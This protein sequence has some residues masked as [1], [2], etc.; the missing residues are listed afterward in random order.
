M[1]R[2]L[3]VAVAV[4]LCGGGLAAR[5]VRDEREA[6][7]LNA[8]GGDVTAPG[9]RTRSRGR[10][11]G[12][13]WVRCMGLIVLPGEV[14]TG[15]HARGVD[16][17]ALPLPGDAQCPL[18]GARHGAAAAP[19]PGRLARDPVHDPGSARAEPAA[20]LA[21][22]RP[23]SSAWTSSS[24]SSGPLRP[25][26]P[27]PPLTEALRLRGRGEGE[28]G[29]LSS[30]RARAIGRKGSDPSRSRSIALQA[31]AHDE[32]VPCRVQR[33]RQVSLRR[34]DLNGN[35]CRREREAKRVAGL[36]RQTR[37]YR[38]T[39]RSDGRSPVPDLP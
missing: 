36:V 38:F 26:R 15:A 25:P 1:I 8:H 21:S 20:R 34:S 10:P 6:R 32:A 23:A 3:R 4:L 35:V 39:L 19:R 2:R 33:R 14:P 5:A 9:P 16:H 17:P 12:T 28:E 22:P 24:S 13:R 31:P 7:L 37:N 30:N 18:G 11:A 27:P 29:G